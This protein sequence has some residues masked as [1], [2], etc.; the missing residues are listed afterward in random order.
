MKLKS[1][2][3]YQ[4]YNIQYTISNI[5]NTIYNKIIRSKMIPDPSG[6][7]AGAVVSLKLFDRWQSTLPIFAQY[8]LL[9]AD[10]LNRVLVL[11]SILI[12]DCAYIVESLRAE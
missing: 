5:K 9:L 3:N 10:L 11:L 6:G 8:L 2:A 1:S 12:N 7:L 4:I